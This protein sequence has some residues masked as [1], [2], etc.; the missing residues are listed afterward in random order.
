MLLL[1]LLPLAT[2]LPRLAANHDAAVED[3]DGLEA[4]WQYGLA[5]LSGAG[6]AGAAASCAP[7]A[8]RADA[9]G[10]PIVVVEPPFSMVR[11]SASAGMPARR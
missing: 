3:W 2:P 5:S 4:L 1:S 7:T 11:A 10:H 9:S 6:V 8:D